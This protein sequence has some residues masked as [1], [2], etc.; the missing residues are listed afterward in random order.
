VQLYSIVW[1]VSSYNL[2]SYTNQSKQAKTVVWNNNSRWKP[3]A[4]M[5]CLI[6][7]FNSRKDQCSTSLF[8]IRSCLM[9]FE[10]IGV[11]GLTSLSSSL[12]SLDSNT[13]RSLKHNINSIVTELVLWNCVLL[14]FT[15]V[16]TYPVQHCKE[17]LL[18]VMHITSWWS[19]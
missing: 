12:D 8:I 14:F 19:T 9:F 3:W 7:N 16:V 13:S 4:Y 18:P 6:V 15:N 17:R 2:G 10:P 1:L 11:D 5:N